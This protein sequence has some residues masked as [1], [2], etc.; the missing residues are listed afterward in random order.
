[1]VV[2][3]EKESKAGVVGPILSGCIAIDIYQV[4]CGAVE[5]G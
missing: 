5:C 4:E 3:V 2:E 1:M